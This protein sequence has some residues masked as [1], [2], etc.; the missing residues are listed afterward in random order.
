MDIKLRTAQSINAELYREMLNDIKVCDT[1][2][3]VNEGLIDYECDYYTIYYHEGSKYVGL[4]NVCHC[5]CDETED[6]DTFADDEL[7]IVDTIENF[8]KKCLNNTLNYAYH[9]YPELKR[10]YINWFEE[11]F[12]ET[13]RYTLIQ[14]RKEEQRLLKERQA[15]EQRIYEKEQR[16]LKEQQAEEKRILEEKVGIP[17][18]VCQKKKLKQDMYQTKEGFE[19]ARHGYR[20]YVWNH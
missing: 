4:Y 20:E 11:K 10:S 16:L 18:C 2:R 12:Y 7:V 5:S 15:E 13:D 8:Y 17:C 9:E 14:L 3:V 19:C 6:P 1:E